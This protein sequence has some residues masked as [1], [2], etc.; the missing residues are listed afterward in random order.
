[1]PLNRDP[2]LLHPILATH[3]EGIIQAISKKLPRGIEA[4][5]ISAYRSPAEQFELFKKGRH[6]VNGIWVKKPGGA[7]VTNIDGFR[8]KSNHNYLPCVAIDI[9]LFSGNQYLTNSPHYKHVHAGAKAYGLEWG[10]NWKKFVDQ[11]HIE[12]PVELLFQKDRI[13]DEAV[14]WQRYLKMAGTYAGE[15]D[16]AFGKKSTAALKATTGNEV[17]TTAA[18]KKLVNKYG[19]LPPF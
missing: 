12:I 10:G 2:L 8:K 15:L 6:F 13:L 16:G 18:W 14:Q 1:M 7:T 11:P 19:L 9:G 5:M 17:R 4:K 3:L